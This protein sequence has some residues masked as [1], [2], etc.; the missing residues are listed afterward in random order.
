MVKKA[1]P[2]VAGVALRAKYAARGAHPDYSIEDWQEQ[3]RGGGTLASYWEWV[4][5]SLGSVTPLEVDEADSEFISLKTYLRSMTDAERHAAL[6]L[7]AQDFLDYLVRTAMGRFGDR[8][9]SER[10][11]QAL[12]EMVMGVSDDLRRMLK[13][14][15]A[16]PDQV[17]I[18]LALCVYHLCRSASASEQPE[19]TATD[20]GSS[21]HPH[22][23]LI[24]KD[25]EPSP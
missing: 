1:D 2:I 7:N 9:D 5:E 14:R 11:E 22:L 3:V 16:T 13:Q 17:G 15:R 4:A 24:D 21:A 25:D 18:A 19:R 8:I 20:S 10:D 23:K 12:H 6:V